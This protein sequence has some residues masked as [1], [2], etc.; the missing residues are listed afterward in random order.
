[1]I[2]TLLRP[3]V[4][5]AEAFADDPA[6]VL[7]PDELAV[8]ATAS[9]RR[10]REFATA[11]GCAHAALARLGLPSAAVRADRMGAPLWPEGVVGSITHCSGYRAAAVAPAGQVAALGLDAEPNRPLR[12]DGLLDY[13]TTEQE[14]A[15]LAVLAG[16]VPGV[17]WD[18]LL[19]SAKEAVYKAWYPLAGCRLD[20]RS[21]DLVI[22]PHQGTFTARLLV[23]GPPVG[24]SP[25][26]T[27]SGRWLAGRGL[28]VTA[29]VIGAP[30]ISG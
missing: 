29:V 21:A 8:V 23:P 20:F 19:F 18:K 1:V 25:L 27:L 2:E 6:A 24:G 26:T 7:F 15:R 13:I 30:G 16:Q 4:E 11:R 22:D 9:Q 3:P 5:A 12:A 10:R 17:C 14:R 28:L